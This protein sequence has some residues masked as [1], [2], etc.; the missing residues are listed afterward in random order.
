MQRIAIIGLGLI[1]GSLGLALKQAKL[2]GVEIVGHDKEP[3]AASKAHKKGAVDK[4]EWNLLAAVEGAG[5]VI[6]ATPVMAV[7]DVLQHIGPKLPQDAIVTDAASTKEQVMGWAQEYLP[8]TV[9]FIGGHPM[10]GKESAGVEAAEAGLF[11]GATYCL[12]PSPK[13]Q[14]EA[15][16][17]VA[18]MVQLIGAKPFF[19][20]AAEHDVFVAA[21]SH[22]PMLISCALVTATMRS[23]SWRE[24]SRLAA[25]GYRDISRLASG[26]P[27]MNRDICL[28]NQT[29]ILP[30]LNRYI[31]ELEGYRLLVAEGG[32]SLEKA[33]S[34]AQEG[35]EHWL[36]HR[37][38]GEEESHV[39]IPSAMDQL[40]SLMAGDKLAQRYKDLMKHMEERSQGKK[41]P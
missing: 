26:S 5:M 30:W 4:T 10:A 16:Q 1:G 18:E 6:I 25:S 21:V 31:E 9:S 22:L 19:L 34:L 13:A 33:L 27:E 17:R 8:E 41:K 39:E 38:R 12:V 28:T 40:A 32:E 29:G 20:D 37:E 23:P 35:R 36:L 3:S 11:K 2:Q 7:K 24:M 14:P 15:T